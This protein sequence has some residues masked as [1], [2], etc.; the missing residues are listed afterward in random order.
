MS[1]YWLR[2]SIIN[3]TPPD[4]SIHVARIM[5]V[6]IISMSLLLNIKDVCKVLYIFYMNILTLIYVNKYN[7]LIVVTIL[8]TFFKLFCNLL[9]S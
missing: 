9:Y 6:S 5:G 2:S 3:L 4:L 7:L 1:S 8:N